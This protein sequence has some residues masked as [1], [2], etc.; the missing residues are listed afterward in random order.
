MKRFLAIIFLLL[1]AVPAPAQSASERYSVSLMGLYGYNET[2]RG[3]DGISVTG[4]LPLSSHFEATAAAEAH[5]PG[6]YAVTATARPK[7]QLATGE[8]FIDASLHNRSFSTYC[9]S[10]FN[11]AASAGYRFEY[12]SIQIG[13][14]SHFIFNRERNDSGHS[15]HIV[16][17]LN[18]LYRAA[19]YIR[20]TT[21]RWNA[22]VGLAN[23]TDFEYERTWEPMY[24]LNGHFDI[25]EHFTVLCRFDLKP[26][27]T[28]H[29]V[30]EFWGV[31]ARAGVKYSF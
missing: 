2:W 11:I 3:Y 29:Q 31:A 14:T 21:S 1:A 24:F 25:T 5:S 10:E 30:A 9:I 27:G 13:A 16:E 20:P 7:W 22:G 19:L 23:Y 6:V 18:L 17:P 26:A 8:L 4:F 12:A 15:E 28:F